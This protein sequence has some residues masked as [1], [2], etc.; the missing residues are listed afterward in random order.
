MHANRPAVSRRTCL[1]GAL[2]LTIAP[3][4]V[5]S[6]GA[7]TPAAIEGIDFA[8]QLGALLAAMPAGTI[9]REGTFFY[10]DLAGQLAA[11]GVARPDP[12]HTTRD[13]PEG[14][15]QA[16]VALP[17][18]SRAFDSG[19]DPSWYPAFGFAPAALGQA[20]MLVD[21]KSALALF[22]GGFDPDAVRDALAG[23]GYATD[24][25]EHGEIFTL[26][27]DPDLESTV[28]RLTLGTMNHA[29]VRDDMLVFADAEA[30]IDDVLAVL[31]GDA[32]SM[33]EA[34]RWTG[35]AALFSSDVVGMIPV[36]ASSLAYWRSGATPAATAT[37]LVEMAL[38]VRG[39]ARSEPLAL[40]GEGTPIATP[41]GLPPEP[42]RI[43]ARL[44]YA[45][46]E[47]AAREA[48]EIP[49]RWR[50]GESLVTEEP[51]TALMELVEARVSPVD[52]RAVAIDFVA[53]A[54]NRWSQVIF[55]N[56]LSPFIPTNG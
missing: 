45:D 43:E 6:A 8:S 39:G 48:E 47:I 10:A 51:F 44:R 49:E 40:G 12:D 20:L 42:A 17:L 37:T 34:E 30:R 53:E 1:L 18:A 56:D 23:S 35:L 46:A 16:T 26:G 33:A 24:Q 29:I 3:S 5:Q 7:Q 28:G 19:L 2:A 50:E 55:T 32:P 27:D 11:A 22:R 9:S 52:P 41:A 13:L 25:R 54:P 15:V 38:G 31:A 14:Y 21:G 36:P 4:A